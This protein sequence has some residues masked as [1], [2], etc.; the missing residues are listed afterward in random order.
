MNSYTLCTIV[1]SPRCVQICS[2]CVHV[3]DS[4]KHH[5]SENQGCVP[6]FPA[7]PSPIT[8]AQAA[9]DSGLLVIIPSYN[10]SCNG[11]ITSLRVSVRA[12]GN[13]V[14]ILIG[15]PQGDGTYSLQKNIREG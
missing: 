6:D 10:F 13:S 1:A 12:L 14:A 2:V 7:Y 8:S 4:T 3:C 11:V 9:G 15:R 5:V